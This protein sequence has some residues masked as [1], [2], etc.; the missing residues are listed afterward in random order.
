MRW[1]LQDKL[2]KQQQPKLQEEN[3]KSNLENVRKL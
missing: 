3:A 2:Q 1:Q